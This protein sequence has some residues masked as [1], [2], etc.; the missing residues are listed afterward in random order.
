VLIGGEPESSRLFG[1]SP[2]YP[3]L[4]QRAWLEGSVLTVERNVLPVWGSL[5][6]AEGG[7]LTIEGKRDVRQCDLGSASKIAL[8]QVP[9]LFSWSVLVLYAWQEP[10][11]PP[12]RLVLAGPGWVLLTAAH[13]RMLAQVIGS[14]PGQP[15]R[16]ISNVVRH[17]RDLAACQDLRTQPIDWSFRTDPKGHHRSSGVPGR[18]RAAR[19]F[20]GRCAASR[21]RRTPA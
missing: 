12:V 21:H 9:P 4:P 15:G 13:L 16:K 2:A 19:A 6:T 1:F 17:L 14:R 11:S 20:H 7:L 5:L 8:R 10:G 3:F 18:R